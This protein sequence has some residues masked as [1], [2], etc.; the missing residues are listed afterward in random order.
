M[1]R[2]V[3]RSPHA[4]CG[5]HQANVTDDELH[6]TEIYNDYQRP[7]D[8]GPMIW[9]RLV[10]DSNHVAG[11]SLIRSESQPLFG[12]EELQSLSALVP[13]MRQ[14]LHVSRTLRDL[15]ASNAMLE[16]GLEETGI[17]ICL[18]RQ[19]GSILRLT[20]GWKRS[21]RH[22]MAFDHAMAG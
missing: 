18:A 9:G 5:L 16:H 21:L 3:E 14:A 13:H 1:Q 12:P 7:F 22:Q 8:I 6:R 20:R 19:D 4:G 10:E 11:L 17:A 2:A 15:E